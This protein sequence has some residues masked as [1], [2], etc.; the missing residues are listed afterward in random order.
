MDLK[1]T[2][3]VLKGV[4]VL[5]TKIVA[6]IGD[7]VGVDDVIAL[8]TDGE[9]RNAVTAAVTGIGNVDD[10]LKDLSVDEIAELVTAATP[11]IINI[12]KALRAAGAK[13]AA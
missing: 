10:E 13:R 4:E 11:V 2:K 7:G 6:R 1:E 8:A 3:E 12:I 5:A 9:L